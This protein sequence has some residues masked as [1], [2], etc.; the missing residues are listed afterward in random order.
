L[1]EFLECIKYI[2]LE[3]TPS[4]ALF[5]S[6]SPVLHLHTCVHIICTLFIILPLPRYPAKTVPQ[7]C[8]LPF[9]LSL[10][11]LHAKILKVNQRRKIRIFSG[12]YGN[13]NSPKHMFRKSKNVLNFS[14]PPVVM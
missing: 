2:I 3:F 1:Q 12:F 8:I 13:M 10:L 5:H 14:K 4:T 9:S 7:E 6:P 11:L